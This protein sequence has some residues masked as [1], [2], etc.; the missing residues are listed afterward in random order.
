MV[1]LPDFDYGTPQLTRLVASQIEVLSSMTHLYEATHHL[2]KVRVLKPIQ[3]KLEKAM[4]KAFKA[5]GKSFVKGLVKL[6][7]KFPEPTTEVRRSWL[8]SGLNPLRE[9]LVDDELK[10]VFDN[11]EDDSLEAFVLPLEDAVKKALLAAGKQQIAELGYEL[12][13]KLSNPR[14]VAYIKAHG[15]ELVT[16]IN[17]ETRSQ[18]KTLITQATEEGWS[19]QETAREII[20]KYDGMAVGVPGE[21]TSR[22]ERIAVTEAGAAFEEGN[23]IPIQDLMDG[24][25]EMQKRWDVAPELSK[26][27]PCPDC[28]ANADEDWIPADQE[29][30]SGDMHPLQHVNCYC[31][32]M[33]E[34]KGA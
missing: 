22:A 12:N 2:S 32:E 23:F 10:V 15:A 19:Y 9:V 18:I 13:F 28:Q 5:Q 20:A 16:K 14:A 31:E 27:G 17:D 24:G 6:K 7:D 11:S 25:I 26:T 8:I 29:H 30:Q 3:S 21:F 33:Y 4:S 34:A 1:A